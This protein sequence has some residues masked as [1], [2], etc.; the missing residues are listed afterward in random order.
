MCLTLLSPLFPLSFSLFSI[1][2]SST[3]PTCSQFSFFHFTLCVIL[4]IYKKKQ[5]LLYYM[6]LFFVCTSTCRDS[7]VLTEWDERESLMMSKK[8]EEEQK[9]KRKLKI[10][11]KNFE[12]G[13]LKCKWGD[14]QTFDGFCWIFEKN[15]KKQKIKNKIK[16]VEE[17]ISPLPLFFFLY[18]SSVIH[19]THLIL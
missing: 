16:S 11:N 2:V 7:K 12:N 17:Y 5:S 9:T 6:V 8:E 18:L 13:L 14:G 1:A 10:C 19:R 4:G 3:F 15:K